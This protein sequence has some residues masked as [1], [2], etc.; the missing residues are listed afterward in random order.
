MDFYF[1]RKN[2]LQFFADEFVLFE[3]PFASFDASTF[4][5]DFA[6]FDIFELLEAFAFDF[7]PNIV[8]PPIL[9]GLCLVIIGLCKNKFFIQ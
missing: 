2:Y 3:Q 6:E 4:L 1:G 7:L 9:Q 8:S 5:V